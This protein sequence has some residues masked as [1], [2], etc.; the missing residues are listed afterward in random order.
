MSIDV[1]ISPDPAYRLPSLQILADELDE[2]KRTGRHVHLLHA[3]RAL[4]E[5][6]YELKEFIHHQIPGQIH[7]RRL[8]VGPPER[9]DER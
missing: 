9:H 8:G 4:D 7:A 5:A 6:R 2:Y 1:R 3:V